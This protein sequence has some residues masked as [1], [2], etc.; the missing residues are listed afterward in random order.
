L[1]WC[2]GEWTYRS[3]QILPSEAEIRSNYFFKESNAQSGLGA[4]CCYSI[5]EIFTSRYFREESR[6]KSDAGRETWE[7]KVKRRKI[8]ISSEEFDKF[9]HALK[10]NDAQEFTLRS[11]IKLSISIQ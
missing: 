7:K 3:A 2:K 6:K 8:S 10:F 9:I 1:H 5:S 4:I 11:A